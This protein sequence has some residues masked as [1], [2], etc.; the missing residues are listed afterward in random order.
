MPLAIPRV[1]RR[2]AIGLRK[3]Y[4]AI[5]AYTESS[6]DAH[7][8]PVGAWATAGN[9]W[10]F[11]QPLRGEE[12]LHAQQIKSTVTHRC[13]MEFYSGLTTDHRINFNGRNFSIEAVL[14]VDEDN[15]EHV[16]ACSEVT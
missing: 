4:L 1:T 8:A 14:D 15:R 3:H 2:T 5:Q 7:G 12:L 11:M 10:G 13:T 9:R 6:R 16:V